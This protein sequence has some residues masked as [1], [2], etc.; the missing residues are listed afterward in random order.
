MIL[1]NASPPVI[2][3]ILED[4]VHLAWFKYTTEKM[5]EWSSKGVNKCVAFNC[6]CVKELWTMMRHV[7]D[8]MK[9]QGVS[10]NYWQ[11]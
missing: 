1:S 3:W 7:L 11:A 2:R 6:Y 9:P 10:K 5:N 8:E 4:L